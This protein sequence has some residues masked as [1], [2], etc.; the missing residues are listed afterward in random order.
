MTTWPYSET[1]YP[2]SFPLAES[3]HGLETSPLPLQ[4]KIECAKSELYDLENDNGK[5]NNIAAQQPATGGG[6]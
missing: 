1:L 4:L 2:F 5:G 3:A 6:V